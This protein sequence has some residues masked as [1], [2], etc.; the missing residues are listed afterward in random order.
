MGPHEGVDYN[1][2]KAQQ[3]RFGGSSGSSGRSFIPIIDYGGYGVFDYAPPPVIRILQVDLIVSMV[4]AGMKNTRSGTNTTE[5]KSAGRRFRWRRG[6]LTSSS[7]PGSTGRN[8]SV[9]PVRM[10]GFCSSSRSIC[11]KVFRSDRMKERPDN[12]GD[13][14]SSDFASKF[15]RNMPAAHYSL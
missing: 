3:I 14:L 4:E 2:E 5:E 12:Y 9:Q 7:M 10:N 15:L 13:P 1:G 8:S 11:D 6:S